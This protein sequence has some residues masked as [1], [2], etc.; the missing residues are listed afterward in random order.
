MRILILA[1]GLLIPPLLLADA[2]VWR[3]SEDGF[4]PKQT[5]RAVS[6]VGEEACLAYSDRDGRLM[7]R[8]PESPALA[9]TA[10]KRTAAGIALESF[11][12][13]LY[14]A[15]L[16]AGPGDPP[17]IVLRGLNQDGQWSDARRL[18]T[19]TQ[20][21]PRIR[22]SGNPDGQLAVV[23][24]GDAPDAPDGNNPAGSEPVA[25]TTPNY[26]L[27]GRLSAD[28]G[29]TWGDVRRLTAGFENGFWPALTMAG[30]RVHFFADA[31]RDGETYL[32]H[33]QSDDAG[34]WTPAESIKTVGSVLL[35]AATQTGGEPLALWFGTQGDGFSLESA[36]RKGAQWKTYRFPGSEDYDIGSMD[37][38]AH[39]DQV[40][41]VFSARPAL[42]TAL[43]RKNHVYFTRSLDGGL[44]WEPIRRLRHDPFD[45]TQDHLPQIAVGPDGVLIVVWNDYRNIRGDLYYN[46]SVDGGT[47][48]LARDRP[49]D[50]PGVDE[51]TLFPFVNNLVM[52][53]GVWH[54]LAARYRDDGLTAADLY[55]YPV[56]G[57]STVH[58]ADRPNDE[59]APAKRAQLEARVTAFWSA[60]LK[61][62]YGTA[63]ALYDPYFRRRMRQDDYIA[64]SGR[65]RHHS[66]AI[67]ET[68]VAG[69]VAQVKVRF[70]YEI[71]KLTLPRGGTY[72]RP[73]T[74]TEITETWIFIDGQWHKEYHNEMGDFAFTRY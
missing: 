28:G 12:K 25:R 27:Y 65:V 32:V 14:A 30:G 73:P 19:V 5:P 74:A 67:Q 3:V 58:M 72:D 41:L 13:R 16:D 57:I 34:G 36:V 59:D 55:L 22:L 48:W 45:L 1:A 20:P 29:Q 15:W 33:A 4:D 6:V 54:A 39:G 10:P 43:P 68:R 17:A 53:H 35:I 23:W 69:N 56:P 50:M 31:R 2:S 47:S 40:Y 21:L 7:V 52:A 64:Q 62:D 61:A 60:L 44:S 9:L 63:Y 70:V 26:H 8:R 46:L 24:L 42:V 51:E 49:L 66:F 71:P 38:V 18:D 11:G 37:L